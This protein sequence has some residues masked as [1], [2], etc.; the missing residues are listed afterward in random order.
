MGGFDLKAV[1]FS[2]DI[3]N[4]FMLAISLVIQIASLFA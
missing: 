3:L 2:P 1:L 4:C